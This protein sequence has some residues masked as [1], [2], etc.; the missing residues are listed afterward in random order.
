MVMKLLKQ[1][2]GNLSLL[3]RA[4]TSARSGNPLWLN[5]TMWVV[6][7]IKPDGDT[8]EIELKEI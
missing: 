5:A 2:P 7:S 1:T 6:V 8:I 3:N 4:D